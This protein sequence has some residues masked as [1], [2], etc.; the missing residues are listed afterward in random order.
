MGET[1]RILRPMGVVSSIY[2]GWAKSRSGAAGPR[3]SDRH[4]GALHAADEI[5]EC[6]PVVVAQV[7]QV[8][9]EV[10]EIVAGADF[11][12]LAEVTIY[13]DQGASAALIDIREVER[14]PL[15]HALPAPEEPPVHPQHHESRGVVEERPVYAVEA[16]L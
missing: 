14:S 4:A 6:A 15:D 8:V 16:R 11:E 5:E 13:P 7:G 12:M 10:G 1:G 2:E 3:R 9:G